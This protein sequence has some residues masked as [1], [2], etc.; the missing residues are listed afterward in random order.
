[1]IKLALTV[2]LPCLGTET[3]AG[4][5]PASMKATPLQ[6]T[7]F[8]LESGDTLS[9]DDAGLD[10]RAM[11]WLASRADE[12][13]TS[14]GA[15]LGWERR[16][17]V[18]DDENWLY[19]AE[20]FPFFV[21]ML[22]TLFHLA[23]GPII[24][25][26]ILEF[27]KDV[28]KLKENCHYIWQ[29]MAL[30]NALLITLFVPMTLED[31]GGMLDIANEDPAVLRR[32]RAVFGINSAMLG[33]TFSAFGFFF[34]MIHLVYSSTLDEVGM[35]RYLV[36][37]PACLGSTILITGYALVA[38]CGFF[39]FW[40]LLALGT[41]AASGFLAMIVSTIIIGLT[42]RRT[43]HFNP[44]A[45]EPGEKRFKVDW[46][47]I[48]IEDEEERHKKMMKTGHVVLK[49]CTTRKTVQ[50]L[51]E[52]Y[53]RCQH[54]SETKHLA[55]GFT[56]GEQGQLLAT[57]GPDSQRLLEVLKK[58]NLTEYADRFHQHELTYSVLKK[59]CD[60]PVLF[61][62][63]VT[64]AGMNL[65]GKR[66]KLFQALAGGDEDLFVEGKIVDQAGLPKGDPL[67]KA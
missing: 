39:R 38:L 1:M 15:S 63:A 31:Y 20:T 35:A 40:G 30:V 65:S 48:E 67:I 34:P 64:T 18:M 59:A 45:G 60:T 66:L 49:R 37:H 3:N 44:V 19:V 21:F 54:A 57:G 32:M 13:L 42:F 47:W 8:A 43:S 26:D 9:Y 56:S 33:V 4:T 55:E 36:A 61:N 22:L 23:V 14:V 11:I 25:L 12:I 28:G 27:Y 62:D 16:L 41:K 10:E 17:Q 50:N 53:R 5:V 58:L 52:F 2:V 46:M 29:N 6:T 24:T 7:D 51:V